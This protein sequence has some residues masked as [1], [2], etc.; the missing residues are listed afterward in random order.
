MKTA[1][2]PT[3]TEHEERE[4]PKAQVAFVPHHFA[5]W[6]GAPK[7]IRRCHDCGRPTTDYRCPRYWARLRSRGGYAPKGGVSDADTVTYGP[8]Q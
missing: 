8:V 2:I 6:A 4:E 3:P 7:N 1:K 5:G